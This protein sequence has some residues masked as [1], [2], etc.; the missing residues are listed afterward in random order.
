MTKTKECRRKKDVCPFLLLENSRPLSPQPPLD[1]L[2]TCLGIDSLILSTSSACELHEN[3]SPEREKTLS[4]CHDD[5][6]TVQIN[7]YTESMWRLHSLKISFFFLLPPSFQNRSSRDL[8]SPSPHKELQWSRWVLSFFFIFTLE[9]ISQNWENHYLRGRDPP[10]CLSQ[11]RTLHEHRILRRWL[12]PWAAGRRETKAEGCFFHLPPPNMTHLS[13]F[14]L[15]QSDLD[16]LEIDMSA[17][18]WCGLR[19]QR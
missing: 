1:F 5:R 17:G 16:Y 18:R 2:S 6:I 10:C 9:D 7:D 8:I 19:S 13:L 15:N 14:V 12:G 11:N 3:I 4:K